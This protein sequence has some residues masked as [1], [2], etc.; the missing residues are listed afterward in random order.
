MILSV[1]LTTKLAEEMPWT[2]G[3]SLTSS[4]VQSTKLLTLVKE[5][6]APTTR[7]SQ[8]QDHYHEHQSDHHPNSDL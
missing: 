4:L 2:S 7:P 3:L 1:C 5:F 6:T 8:D